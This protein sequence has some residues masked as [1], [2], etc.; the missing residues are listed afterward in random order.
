LVGIDGGVVS[1]VFNL[2]SP[3]VGAPGRRPRYEELATTPELS[4][5]T[6][7]SNSHLFDDW[8]DPIESGIRD[9]VR[10]LIE[11][12][13][14]G[15]LD[16]ALSRPRY[17]RRAAHA[18]DTRRGRPGFF[19]DRDRLFG[20]LQLLAQPLRTPNT[21]AKLGTLTMPVLVLAADADHPIAREFASLTVAEQIAR[22]SDQTAYS[23]T[24]N[25]EK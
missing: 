18:E 2:E 15:E 1:G 22:R 20:V 9:R 8:F 6:T 16:A 25:S 5:S 14:G 17:G 19:V 21:Y 3:G 13:I 12:M 4:H 24:P 7:E 11:E 23:L 10:G